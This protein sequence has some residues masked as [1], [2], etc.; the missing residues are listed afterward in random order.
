MKIF[1]GKGDYLTA[2]VIADMKRFCLRIFFDNQR[3]VAIIAN[4]EI[5]KHDSY[6]YSGNYKKSSLEKAAT[7]Y[8]PPQL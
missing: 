6:G 1:H 3:R 8:F 2:V 4:F 7:H 5:R